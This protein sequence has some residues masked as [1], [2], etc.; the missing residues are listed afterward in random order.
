MPGQGGPTSEIYR[1][2]DIVVDAGAHTVLRAG[3]PQT[4]EPKAFS[5]LLVL[6]RHKGEL[7]AR[8]DLLDEVWGHR[9]VTPGVLTRVI[10]QLRHVLGDDSQ[11]PRY[12]QTQ[13]ALGYRFI[14]LP[15]RDSDYPDTSVNALGESEPAET[16]VAVRQSVPASLKL[17]ANEPHPPNGGLG[18]EHDRRHDDRHHPQLVSEQVESRGV[19]RIMAN[20]LGW[21]GL[22]ALLTALAIWMAQRAQPARAAE[23][24]IAVLPFTSLSEN[25]SDG[26]FA[27][28]LTV[29]M[30]DALAGV[31]GLKVIAAPQSGG[32]K[33]GDAKA[34]GA[35]LGVATLLDASVRRE[36]ARVRINARLTDARTGFTLWTQSYDRE[37][38]D[39]FGLQSEIA[40][41][42]V[43]SLLG[44]LPSDGQ[45]LARRLAPTRNI[46]A[47][48][49]YLKGRQQLQERVGDANPDS[50]IN[51]FRGALAIDPGFARAQAGICRAEITRFEAARDATAFDRAQTAC[52][53]ASGMDPSLREVSLALGELHRTRGEYDQA[54][55]HYTHALEDP[56]LRADAYLGLAQLASAQ[57][58]N[59]LATDYFERARKLRP[60]DP[61]VFR[62][63]GYHLYT[64]GD[65]AG[66][67]ES[68]RTAAALQPGDYRTWYALGG[69][70]Q[71]KGD[72][73]QASAAFE[74]SLQ[75][76]P[77]YPALSNLGTLK[78]DSGAYAE[79][80][81]L[82][83]HAVELD[84][85]DFRLWGNIGDAL[86][87]ASVDPVEAQEYYREAALRA[88]R[89]L[90]IR[91][92]DAQGFA[93]LAWYSANLGDKTKAR[94]M[95]GK[96][97]ALATERGEVALWG[98]Q[99]MAVLDDAEA[100]REQMAKA[101]AEGIPQQRIESIP[102]LRRLLGEVASV[103]KPSTKQ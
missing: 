26:Y 94:D 44:V 92:D 90:K 5:V 97:E 99:T 101:R 18:P 4:I 73:V 10:A 79:A 21:G 40:N 46:A 16:I 45:A 56:S 51:Y 70:Y 63:R 75:I 60:R 14:G 81:D 12:I 1:F 13:H 23:A 83:R 49:A 6:L 53:R 80:A 67:I 55:E 66:A 64:S 8:D 9:H 57:G 25:K 19:R 102:V 100:A 103:P 96:A 95:Q 58:R 86:S 82:Y 59:P 85:S 32:V 69:L 11:H 41:E 61:L 37:T 68:Y 30:H 24:S 35:Q 39:V 98:A 89:Y 28:G 36:G 7:V 34:L 31:P 78:F 50:A 33:Q 72:N 91:P 29:E 42:V 52:K 3:Q 48:D 87:A 65:V 27:D 77:N 54:I 17:A 76:K 93:Q 15:R 84:P 47:Y 38:S 20:L 43:Q 22:L 88:E 74:R 2:D 62:E 71:V